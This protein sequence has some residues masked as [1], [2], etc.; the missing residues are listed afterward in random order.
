MNR[1]IPLL[2]NKH[3]GAPYRETQEAIESACVEGRSGL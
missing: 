1:P 2:Q 3:T